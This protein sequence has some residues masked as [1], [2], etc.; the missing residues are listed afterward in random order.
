MTFAR[1]LRIVRQRLRSLGHQTQL[2]TELDQELAF[3]FDQLV[4]EKTADGLSVAEA[5]LAAGREFGSLALAADQSRDERRVAWFHDLRQDI[6]YGVRT[7]RRSPG[8]TAVAL[9]SLALG[10][11]A[12]AVVLGAIDTVMF[13]GLP[14]ANGDRLVQI[15]T[16]PLEDPG[17]NR[18]ALLADYIAWRDGSGAFDAM[19]ASLAWQSDFGADDNGTPPERLIGQAVTPGW[20]ATL[21]IP[22]LHGR[23]F[24]DDEIRPGH[25]VPVI[26]ISYRIWQ[27]RFGADPNIL[28]KRVRVDAVLRTIIGVMPRDF[29]YQDRRVDYWLP[30]RDSLGPAQDAQRFYGVMARLKPGVTV[31]RAQADLDAIA[32]RLAGE[33]PDR[34]KGWGVRVQPL[35]E[36]LFEWAKTP[37]LTLEAAV[38]FVLLIACANIAGLLLAR[39]SARQR[40]MSLRVALGAGRARIIRQLLTESLVLSGAG[41]L[42]GVLVAWLG[43]RGLTAA[44]SPPIGAPRMFALDMSGHMLGV[45]ALLAIVAG[46]GF[47]LVPALAGSHLNLAGSLKESSP[48]PATPRRRYHQTALVAAQIALALIL[49][50]GSALLLNSFVRL[51]GRDLGFD[52]HGLVSLE[53]HIPSLQYTRTLGVDRGLPFFEINPAPSITIQR[54]HERLR[55]LPGVES[56]AGISYPHVNSLVLPAL[57]VVI[58]GQPAPAGADPRARPPA[59]FLVTPGFFATVRTP[60]VRGRD[61]DDHDT[62][63]AP[64]VAIV[65]ETA[66]RRLWPGD[67][68]IG[69]RFTL[70]A[71]PDERPREV[72]GVVRDIPIRS[73]QTTPE[74]VMYASYLQQPARYRGRWGGMFGQMTFVLRRAGDRDDASVVSAARRAAAEVDPNRPLTTVDTAGQR[75]GVLMVEFRDY[76]L[77]LTVFAI[78]ATLLA[79]IGIYGV[80]AYSV[81]ERTREIGVR[82]ALGAGTREIVAL[83]GRR[84]LPLIAAGLIFGL[85]GAFAL[86]R[87]IASQLWGIAPTDPTTF[88]AVS[89]LLACV[90]VVACLVPT[91]RA[92]AVDPTIALRN[93]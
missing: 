43:L 9:T 40:E 30:L 72:V 13:E 23:V 31:E 85:A 45:T 87:W 91:R 81:T 71:G 82:R 20:F 4:K 18:N 12:N 44:V 86:T 57:P 16:V 26:V 55:A 93:E 5:R 24:T 10:I 73:R 42:L 67:E 90:A 17:Q 11:G 27:R 49:L 48:G 59:Y 54:V 92:L 37:L 38:A 50:I 84:A 32:G 56:A 83:I 60:L 88:A 2:D 89:L 33:S 52:P 51:A 65:N 39:G 62:A 78:A 80:M 53:F 36:A 69:K 6:V 3:H 25:P 47:G 35:R 19:G 28:E 8:F 22:P 74:P 41:G 70:D 68:A 34:S 7:L 61:V 63:S 66:A 1:L 14:L 29:Q 76:I 46:L 64:W 77:V 58:D 75:L 79:A 21:G 15:R